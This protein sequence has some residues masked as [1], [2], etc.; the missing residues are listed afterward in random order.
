[1]SDLTILQSKFRVFPTKA[2]QQEVPIVCGIIVQYYGDE[3]VVFAT[4]SHILTRLSL[5]QCQFC[6]CYMPETNSFRKQIVSGHV[7]MMM[8]FGV[9]PR[10][11]GVTIM[12]GHGS[13]KRRL[14]VV[15]VWT[16]RYVT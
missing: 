12:A 7:T 8:R 10:E 1:M 14:S 9:I 11:F 15:V 16:H 13:V 4:S 3:V 2:L 6:N 5:F